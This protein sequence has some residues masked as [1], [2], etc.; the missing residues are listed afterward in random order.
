[1]EENNFSVLNDEIDIHAFI[2]YL[3]TK[4]RLILGVS[5]LVGGLAFSSTFFLN[6]KYTSVAVLAPSD[7]FQ[8]SS[9]EK[10]A[11]RFG[12]LASLA[13]ISLPI[14]RT[15]KDVIA[16]E[17]L[18]S[19]SFVDS[20]IKR[21]KLTVELMAG[22]SWDQKTGKL[23]IN[24]KRYDVKNQKWESGWLRSILSDEKP[25]EPSSWKQY[26]AFVKHLKVDRNDKTGL[27]TIS[28]SSVSP[29][30]AQTWLDLLIKNV[31]EEYKQKDIENI[32][33][34]IA[35]LKKQVRETN[36]SEMKSIFYQLIE[37]QT[38][39]YM[40]AQSTNDY[41]FSVVS[42]P[43]TP[44]VNQASYPK[45][46]VFLICGIF[47]GMMGSVIFLLFRWKGTGVE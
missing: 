4:K 29:V 6:K 47:L 27:T 24:P 22:D 30:L 15:Q 11:S 12:G 2:S 14:G 25:R 23:K 32:K 16:I 42:S 33:T 10:L 7:K 43:M 45:R 9:L 39:A 38:K 40:V 13:G 35:Y 31:N 18:T 46:K 5:L 37:E 28:F 21:N 3:F 1:M 44:D 41:V 34:N 26:K 17:M 19:W 20:F 36:L 8:S